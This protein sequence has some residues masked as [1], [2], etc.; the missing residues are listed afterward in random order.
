MRRSAIFYTDL[1]E[2]PRFGVF[3]DAFPG[4]EVRVVTPYVPRHLSAY[5]NRWS[6]QELNPGCLKSSP[7]SYHSSIE[8]ALVPL[9]VK[10]GHNCVNVKA[11]RFRRTITQAA[12]FFPQK[13]GI[14][15]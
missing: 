1:E 8:Y 6:G 12:V 4:P 7:R 11:K 5:T 10:D 14:D 3:P 15:R 2:K 13:C 9:Y